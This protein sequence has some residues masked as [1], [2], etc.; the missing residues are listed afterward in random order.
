[1]LLLL[2]QP[3]DWQQ[4]IYNAEIGAGILGPICLV[5]G[6]AKRRDSRFGL[7][8]L[9]SLTL[10]LLLALQQQLFWINSR[11]QAAHATYDL[12]YYAADVCLGPPVCFLACDMF[13]HNLALSDF[14]S[15]LYNALGQ[16]M[17]LCAV[18][19]FFRPV[20]SNPNWYVLAVGLAGA[21]G[22]MV[23]PGIGPALTFSEIFPVPPLQ[24]PVP[25]LIFPPGNIVRNT[26][27]S[28]HVLWAYSIWYSLK[29]QSLPL[30]YL[31]LFYVI[32][33][34]VAAFGGS[35][36]L[37]DYL[38]SLAFAP[39]LHY[40]VDRATGHSP[41]I[42]PWAAW[43]LCVA[44][45]LGFG[46]CPLVI[47][48]YSVWSVHPLLLKAYSGLCLFMSVG[49]SLHLTWGASGKSPTTASPVTAEPC[50]TES[51]QPQATQHE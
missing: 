1:M 4:V 28:L 10:L 27:P 29:G 21:C 49:L 23:F 2:N 25:R 11:G 30:A 9:H 40:L 5:V 35:H 19:W 8:C 17:S 12:Y 36:Y 39:S 41:P 42:R 13:S 6:W 24:A 26:M 45:A 48:G 34:P 50:R 37:V 33:M 43:G 22:Y 3:R 14:F 47:A 32:A 38:P 46:L 15:L 20:G 51:G 16:M 31:G 44:A 7:A 18:C